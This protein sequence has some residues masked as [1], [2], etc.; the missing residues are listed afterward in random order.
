MS[1]YAEIKEN[2]VVNVIVCEDNIISTMPGAY[3]KI[4]NETKEAAIGDTF[5]TINLKFVAPKP[6]ESWILDENFNW[7]SPIGENPNPALK[8][9]DEE[10]Q[11]WLDR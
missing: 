11:S 1:K 6:Y 9:W 5:D 4:T 2:V 3:I 7:I 10:T 8:Y